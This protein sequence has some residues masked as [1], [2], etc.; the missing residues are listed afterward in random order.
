[1]KKCKHKT[2]EAREKEKQVGKCGQQRW[3]NKNKERATRKRTRCDL[4]RGATPRRAAHAAQSMLPPNHSASAKT[5]WRSSNGH[6]HIE[7]RGGTRPQAAATDDLRSTRS[8][9]TTSSSM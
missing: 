1:M 6:T 4:A 2:N 8:R 5:R 7:L 3:I 9:L